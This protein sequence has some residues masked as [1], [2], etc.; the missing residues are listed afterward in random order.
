MYA[1]IDCNLL[2]TAIAIRLCIHMYVN[3]III[4][5]NMALKLT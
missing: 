1:T 4:T 5:Y 2:L 3:I